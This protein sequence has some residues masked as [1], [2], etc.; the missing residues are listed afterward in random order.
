MS[1]VVRAAFANGAF[2]WGA[3]LVLAGLLVL[4]VRAAPRLLRELSVRAA[5][6]QARRARTADEHQQAKRVLK[7]LLKHQHPP[8]G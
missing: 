1:E 7:M 4:F 8:D 2:V 3:A 6:R 5:A